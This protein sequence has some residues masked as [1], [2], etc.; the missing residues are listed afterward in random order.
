LILF[1]LI[2]WIDFCVRQLEEFLLE[3]L[4]MFKRIQ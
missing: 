3:D 2:L 4:E 1:F